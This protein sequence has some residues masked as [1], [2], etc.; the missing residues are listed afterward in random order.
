MNAQIPRPRS[1]RATTTAADPDQQLASK[2]IT[3]GLT[4]RFCEQQPKAKVKL[5]AELAGLS[6]ESLRTL[7][8]RW[9]IE[10]ARK[11]RRAE[12]AEEIAAPVLSGAEA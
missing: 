8:N 4:P 2:A 7:L 9:G 6:P 5:E 10:G 3:A 12:E 1:A 11:V